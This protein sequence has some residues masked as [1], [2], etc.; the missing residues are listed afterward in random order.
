VFV[1]NEHP[2]YVDLYF[3]DV[4]VSHTPSPIVGTSDYFPFGLSYN[5]GERAGSLEQKYLYNG[6]ELQDEM[7]LN[8]YYYGARMYAAEIGRWGVVDPLTEKAR[9][10]TPYNYGLNNPIRFVDPDGMQA[11]DFGNVTFAGY[12][13]IGEGG[14]ITGTTTGTASKSTSTSAKAF[15]KAW[16]KYFHANSNNGQSK[17]VKAVYSKFTQSFVQNN[18]GG[19]GA[20]FQSMDD[21]AIDW[22][23][24]YN[25]NSIVG[26]AE[27]NSTI[28]RKGD[29]Y[30]Y[31]KPRVGSDYGSYRSRS[32]IGKVDVGEIHSHAAFV[33]RSDDNFSPDDID[34]YKTMGEGWTAYL[35]TPM[36]ALHKWGTIEPISTNLPS[37][38]KSIGQGRYNSTDAAIGP[39]DEPTFEFVDWF[40]LLWPDD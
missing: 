31:T 25:D 9:K 36:G 38:P 35:A 10:W 40:K 39:K 6:K 32:G 23:M 14:I 2:Y 12:A 21:A 20:K 19:A 16:S 17:N 3:D 4:T 26:Q 29:G 27:Y 5:S 8:W 30:A 11:D 34:G 7:A 33:A 24:K 1:S 13:G 22:G 15:G 37:D 18:P 28:Y